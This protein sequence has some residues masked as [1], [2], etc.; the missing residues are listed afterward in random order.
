MTSNP[1]LKRRT[2]GISSLLAKYA[3]KH[4]TVQTI[5]PL[6]QQQHVQT[7]ALRVAPT[8]QPRQTTVSQ[9]KQQ[10]IQK[11]QQ[12]NSFQ[13]EKQTKA[14]ALGKVILMKEGSSQ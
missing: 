10:L 3:L 2:S 1:V 4:S 5:T 7:S 8:Q 11:I 6:R 14:E 13:A 12:E 9:L